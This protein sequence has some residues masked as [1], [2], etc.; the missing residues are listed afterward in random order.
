M[1]ACF[2]GFVL[3]AQAQDQQPAPQWP[4]L[5]FPLVAIGVLWYF[6]LLRPQQRERQK[7]EALLGMLKKNDRVVTIG[8]IIG[9]VANLSQDGKEVT[10]KVDDNTRLRMLRS[11][12]QTV[13]SAESTEEESK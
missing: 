6:M 10:L 12:I 1:T 2:A 3:F 4:S 13:L 7:R 9:T 8:G 5:L 11:S